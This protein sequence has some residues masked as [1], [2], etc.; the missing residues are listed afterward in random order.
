[1]TFNPEVYIILEQIPAFPFFFL[2]DVILKCRSQFLQILGRGSARGWR[3]IQ[4]STT[5]NVTAPWCPDKRLGWKSRQWF[6]SQRGINK[7]W[8]TSSIYLSLSKTRVIAFPLLTE[9]HHKVLNSSIWKEGT[10]HYKNV[11]WIISIWLHK[12]KERKS[13]STPGTFGPRA[14]CLVQDKHLDVWLYFVFFL[15]LLEYSKY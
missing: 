12:D 1:M 6:Y 10:E 4:G 15:Q 3:G 5:T 9:M 2:T 11:R 8:S 7:I 13:E 14:R